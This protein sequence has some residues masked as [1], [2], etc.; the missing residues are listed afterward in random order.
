VNFSYIYF[1]KLPRLLYL[2][3]EDCNNPKRQKVSITM[4]LD[5]VKLIQKTW[6]NRLTFAETTT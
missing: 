3:P 5:H 4:L 6:Y 2:K 1:I